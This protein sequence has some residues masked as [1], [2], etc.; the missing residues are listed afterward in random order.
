MVKSTMDCLLNR[1]VGNIFEVLECDM[2]I[3]HDVDHHD[4][5]Q[6][7]AEE[8][9]IVTYVCHEC[10]SGWWEDPG[11]DCPNCHSYESV[12]VDMDRR[13]IEC[14]HGNA[15]LGSEFWT[16]C[17]WEVYWNEIEDRCDYLANEAY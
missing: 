7:I 1:K 17:R 10:Y 4:V 14:P 13:H 3:D 9:I 16:P 8:D 15:P 5:D 6:R 11:E 2:I 12:I